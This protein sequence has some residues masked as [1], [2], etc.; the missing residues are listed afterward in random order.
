MRWRLLLAA[1]LL[2]TAACHAAAVKPADPASPL[3]LKRV[4][5][6]PDV[7]GRIDHL[8]VDPD[9][10]RLYVAEYGN[11]SV[12]EI[13][14][15]AGRRIRRIGGLHEPQGVAFVPG[16]DEIVVACGDGSVRFYAAADLQERARVDLGDDADN[17]RLDP[18]NGHIIIG[19]G[20]G[21]LAIID[22]AS[23]QIIGRLKLPG[24]PEGFRLTG[25]KVVVNVPD[26]GA[27]IVGDIDR[28][29][30][31]STFSTG[32]HRLNF[33]LAMAPSG[34]WVVLAYRLPA[35]L[36][37]VDL[38]SGVTRLLRPTCGDADD[39]FLAGDH[40]LTI[41]GAG[42]VDV[43]PIEGGKGIRVDTVAGA[44][45]GL[46]IPASEQLLVAVPARGAPAAIWDL[47][48]APQH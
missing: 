15:V 14:L 40:I 10:R 18:R 44:R 28:N 48:F 17:V 24:H 29:L 1:G 36:A 31:V 9:R 22:P 33:P 47:A 4:I 41:C 45:T 43:T 25:S 16:H 34:Q 21:G 27:I 42:H 2:S 38:A 13:D 30:I 12:D 37:I 35:S 23:H 5:A 32:P 7:Q 8:A 20:K 19:Y 11:G 46:F 39:L 3:R 6:L 26:C